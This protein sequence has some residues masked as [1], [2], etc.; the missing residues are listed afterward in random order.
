MSIKERRHAHSLLKIRSAFQSW[1]SGKPIVNL[2][3]RSYVNPF[4]IDKSDIA[5]GTL[6]FFFVDSKHYDGEQSEIGISAV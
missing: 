1:N 5:L 4:E 3:T 2:D 6:E